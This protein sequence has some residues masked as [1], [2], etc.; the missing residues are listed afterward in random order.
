MNR[1]NPRVP[2]WSALLATL[3][4]I[5]V[6]LA[7]AADPVWKVTPP[8]GALFSCEGIT[9]MCI[10]FEAVRVK[11]TPGD[12][13][14]HEEWVVK[15]ATEPG[16]ISKTKELSVRDSYSGPGIS[17]S[18]GHHFCLPNQFGAFVMTVT[19][20]EE[21]MWPNPD[22]PIPH[23]RIIVVNMCSL[24]TGFEENVAANFFSGCKE[25]SDGDRVACYEFQGDYR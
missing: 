1:L 5:A 18:V 19:G 21:D 14:S 7:V 3:C 2:A 17:Y 12:A 6:P 16:G 23:F 10:G 25:D 20:R 13:G 11:K 4:A 8:P 22:D 9:Q 24:V 15:L